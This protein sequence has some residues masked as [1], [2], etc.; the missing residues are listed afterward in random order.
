MWPDR[1]GAVGPR[2]QQALIAVAKAVEPKARRVSLPSRTL[3]T[4][5]DVESYVGDVR[6]ALLAEINDGPVVIG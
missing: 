2:A 3:R 6:Q 1:I 5:D 4:A